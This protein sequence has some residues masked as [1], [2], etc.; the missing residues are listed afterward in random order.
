MTFNAA[1]AFLEIRKKYVDTLIERAIGPFPNEDE[2]ILWNALRSQLRELWNGEEFGK[3]IFANP[4][5]EGLFPYPTCGQS[6]DDLIERGVF[7]RDMRKFVADFLLVPGNSLYCH[8]LE[9]IMASKEGKNIIVASGTGSGKTECF[10]YSMI[11]NLLNSETEEQLR[12]D[13]GVRILMIYPMNALVKDQLKRIVKLVNRK[14]PTIRVGMY[15]SQ[16][17]EKDT[18]NSRECWEIEELTG[19]DVRYVR[20]RNEMRETPPHILITNYSMLEYM[21][22][23]QADQNMFA[24]NKLQAIVLDEAHLYSGTL[25]NDINMLLRRVLMRFGKTHQ[26]IRFYATSATIGNN[27]TEELVGAAA[28]L[29][30]VESETIKAISGSR[31]RPC[32]HEVIS[33]TM[34]QDEKEKALVLRAKYLANNSDYMAIDI[35]DVNTLK[36]ISEN[37][38]LDEDGQPFFPYKLHTFLSVPF[39][40]YSDMQLSDDKPLGN[41][42]NKPAFGDRHGLEVFY[43]FKPRRELYFR[44]AIEGVQDAETLDFVFTLFNYENSKPGLKEVYLREKNSL[45]DNSVF[46]YSLTFLP[47]KDGWRIEPD[48]N[49]L[50]V[51]ATK[52]WDGETEWTFLERMA[53]NADGIN[54]Q[55]FSSSGIKLNLFNNRFTDNDSDDD[56]NPNV[57]ETDVE[58][59]FSSRNMMQPLGFVA[60]VQRS[61]ILT[62]LLFPYLPDEMDD[63]G[64]A[65][66]WNGRQLLYFSDTR[67]QAANVAWQLQ[68]GHQESV[69]RSY[70]FQAAKFKIENGEIASSASVAETLCN[71]NDLLIQFSLPQFAYRNIRKEINEERLRNPETEET[72]RIKEC[73]THYQIPAMIYRELAPLRTSENSLEALGAVRVYAIGTIDEGHYQSPQWQALHRMMIENANGRQQW[74]NVILPDLINLFRRKRKVFFKEFFNLNKEIKQ[75]GDTQEG[76]R[77]RRRLNMRL[78][79]V[80]NALGYIYSDI[81]ESN[82]ETKYGMFWTST[83]I[84]NLDSA[85]WSRDFVRKYFF[86]DRE[87]N[88]DEQIKRILLAIHGFLLAVATN[89]NNIN[90]DCL[91]V[92]HTIQGRRPNAVSLNFDALAFDVSQ[93]THIAAD[94]NN[95]TFVFANGI[96]LPQGLR[97]ISETIRDSVFAHNTTDIDNY[98]P[99]GEKFNASPLG[100]LRVPE[101]SAQL[102][103]RELADIEEDFKQRRL[104]VI[105]CTPTMEVG[106][107]IG[108]LSAVIQGNLPP[109]KANYI[110]RAG[111]A[112]RRSDASALIL[113]IVND[114]LIDNATMRD[115]L[116]IFKKKNL[117]AP[118]DVSDSAACEQVICHVNQFLLN[119]FFLSIRGGYA[120]SGTPLGAWETVGNVLGNRVILENFLRYLQQSRNTEDNDI[121][122]NKLDR[123][124]SSVSVFL[125]ANANAEDFPRCRVLG[126]V[127]KEKL[128]QNQ[129]GFKDRFDSLI[130]GTACED[131]PQDEMI[132]ELQDKLNECSSAICETMTGVLSLVNANIQNPTAEQTRRIKAAAHQFRNIFT[133]QL[134]AYLIHRRILPAYGFPVDVISFHAGEHCLERSIFTAIGEFTPGSELT[135]AHAK[136]S[137]DALTANNYDNR[138]AFVSFALAK[139]SKCNYVFTEIDGRPLTID[140]RNITCPACGKPIA[141]DRI[142]RLIKPEGYRSWS[143]GEEAASSNSFSRFARIEE[144]LLLDLS[145]TIRDNRPFDLLDVEVI[146]V[147]SGEFG[148][149]YLIDTETGAIEHRQNEENEEGRGNADW[150]ARHP[151]NT[152]SCLA[153]SAKVKTWICAIRD[154][155]CFLSNRESSRNIISA[156]LIC[157]AADFLDLDSRVLRVYVTR[158]EVHGNNNVLFCLYEIS[159]CATNLNNLGKHGLE[160]FADALERILSSDNKDDCSEH[161]LT[162]STERLLA[163]ISNED[164]NELNE[165]INQHQVELLNPPVGINEGEAEMGIFN[166]HDAERW[167]PYNGHTPVFGQHYKLS[168]GSIIVYNGPEDLNGREITHQEI[169]D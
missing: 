156:A 127:L 70:I 1:K 148:A 61:I 82:D 56:A 25:G 18:P 106:V 167:E 102:G 21:M 74:N 26:Q 13:P 76:R 99:D 89:V 5:L 66:P 63:E 144:N 67:A 138:G 8:Q 132:V 140:Q 75:C 166:P 123:Q 37:N 154:F 110:Q 10:L 93:E 20:G 2:D 80:A 131:K 151:Q 98:A 107:D 122:R 68:Y 41:L 120:E 43:I 150:I 24:H 54:E 137:V 100:G 121:T 114:G 6:V 146:I 79:V 164:F 161:L 135:V 62:Q 46:T 117:Y 105:S 15:T 149:G 81:K 32:S 112:G 51:F 94:K 84:Q 23:R 163:K 69:A 104:N 126:Q 47:E 7:H 40:C 158:R 38:A 45:D 145:N 49:G 27:T 95:R 9:A 169:E 157:A 153:C 152:A 39:H 83:Q 88:E 97:D 111:R 59:R 103:V 101:H 115:S 124:I 119:E 147:N 73:Q 91:F 133:E 125:R 139:C 116:S 52:A 31:K 42:Q 44:G 134:I 87:E 50:F 14:T 3:T 64:E 118:A 48:E 109:E 96:Q 108:G 77:T 162:Y 58:K 16:T 53:D 165:W 71:D 65:L 36:S 142:Q 17:P 4:V 86:I 29:F 92:K 28:S 72:N 128:E 22:L 143:E 34:Q 11:N 33:D 141:D 130:R 160:I 12:D 55:W 57:A 78:K 136:Y 113:T 90:N 30:G 159:G 19:R 129:D 168:D 35:E 85:N 60:Q 155:D